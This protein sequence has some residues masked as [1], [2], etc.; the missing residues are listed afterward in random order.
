MP[1]TSNPER[2]ISSFEYIVIADKKICQ[3]TKSKTKENR[4]KVIDI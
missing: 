3:S 4:D 2:Q 1:D